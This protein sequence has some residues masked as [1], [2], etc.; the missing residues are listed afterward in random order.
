MPKI[1]TSRHRLSLI[2][3]FWW[4]CWEWY[5]RINLYILVVLDR[6]VIWEYVEER[7][8]EEKVVRRY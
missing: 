6:V 3:L 2:S 1:C 4:F 8:V 5:H 7:Y